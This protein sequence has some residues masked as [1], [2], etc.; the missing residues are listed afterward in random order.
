MSVNKVILVGRRFPGIDNLVRRVEQGLGWNAAAIQT[1][2]SQPLLAF[3]ENDLFS[4]VRRIK[5]RRVAARPGAT[6]TISVLIGSIIKSCSFS[7]S[8]S[9]TLEQWSVCV[10]FRFLR[11]MLNR[12]FMESG[13]PS[14]RSINPRSIETT[15]NS[16]FFPSFTRSSVA[17][18]FAT[19]ARDMPR[20]LSPSRARRRRILLALTLA[21]TV[22]LCCV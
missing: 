5:R 11:S 4:Q 13:R 8:S 14:D 20:I 15:R 7:S 3:D 22:A 19:N 1:D 16:N 12:L 21:F 6:T 17:T 18:C 10:R 9:K 2:A